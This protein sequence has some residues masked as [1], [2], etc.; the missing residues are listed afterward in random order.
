LD[1]IYSILILKLIH[2]ILP[3]SIFAY[4]VFLQ[5]VL[6]KSEVEFIGLGQV[7]PDSVMPDSVMTDSVIPDS[8]I[9]DSV[10]PDTIKSDLVLAGLNL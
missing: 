8:V 10:I 6:T 7:I 4:P 1:D 5:L 2:T 9:P 3:D